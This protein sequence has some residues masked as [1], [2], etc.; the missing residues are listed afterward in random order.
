M[1]VGIGLYG[2]SGDKEIAPLLKNVSTFRSVVSQVKQIAAGDTVGY[3]RAGVAKKEMTLAIVPV[4]YAD[5]LNRQLSRGGGHLMVGGQRVP[6]V[7]NI[8]MDMCAI[9]VTGL[10][11]SEGDAVV[12]FGEELPVTE[13]ADAL[14]TIPYEVFTAVS[15]RVKRIYYQE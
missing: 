6:I 2:V 3:G 12:I 11:V 10:E 7:G 8:S 1:R 9:D 14:G 13:M 5:G 15:Q 4:G